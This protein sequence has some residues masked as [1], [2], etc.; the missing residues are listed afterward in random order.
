[1]TAIWSLIAFLVAIGLLV[2]F[3]ELG[4]YTAARVC[5]VRVLRFSVG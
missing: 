4:H 5:G 3:H 2:S 1:M